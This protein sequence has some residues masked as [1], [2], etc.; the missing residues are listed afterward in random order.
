MIKYIAKIELQANLWLDTCVLTLYNYV[1][2]LDRSVQRGDAV[3]R[4]LP[5]RAPQPDKYD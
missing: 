2:V 1:P 5:L 3:K 4:D